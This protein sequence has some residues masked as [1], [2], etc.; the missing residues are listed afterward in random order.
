MAESTPDAVWARPDARFPAEEILPAVAQDYKLSYDPDGR[1]IGGISSG[2]I[3]ALHRSL[4]TPGG[5]P[6]GA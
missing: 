2:G 3:C 6:Q 4:G 5:L 1:A